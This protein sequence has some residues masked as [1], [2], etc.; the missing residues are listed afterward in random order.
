MPG[1]KDG[2]DYLCDD[3]VYRSCSCNMYSINEEYRNDPDGEEGVDWQWVVDDEYEPNTYWQKIDL[4]GRT[5]PCCE[6]DYSEDGYDIDD[7]Y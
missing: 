1:F 3:C 7:N 4:K 5:Y 2:N 6:Y